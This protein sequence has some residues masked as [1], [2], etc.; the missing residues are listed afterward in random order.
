MPTGTI[1]FL[2]TDVEGSTRLWEYSPTEARAMLARHDALFEAAVDAAGGWVVRPR[3]EGDS[4]FA[5]FRLA[6]E[7][8][9]AALDFQRAMAS[10]PW[11]HAFRVRAALNTGD[12]DLRDGDYYGSAVNRCARLRGL[13]HGGQTLLAETTADLVADTLPDGA[14]LRDLGSHLLKDLSRP[15]RVFQLG[16]ADAP[17]EFPPLASLDALPTNLPG[18]LTVFVGREREVA[19]VA[20]LIR[21][22]RLVTLTG[23]G[24]V[25]KT[26]LALQVAADLVDDHPHGVWFVDLARVSGPEVVPAVVAR[27]IGARGTE[28]GATFDTI[29][30]HLG[31][32][33]TLLV[34]DNCEHLLAA[35]AELV[36]TVLLGCPNVKVLATAREAL[37]SAGEVSWRVPSLSLP[38]ADPRSPH[39]D[40]AAPSTRAEDSEAVQLFLDRARLVAPEASLEPD[41]DVIGQICRRLD[42]IPLA[43]ELAAARVASMAP[44]EIASRLGDRFRLLVGGRRTALERQQTLRAAI[45]WS[46]EPLDQSERSVFRRLSAFVGGFK[47]DA[48]EAVCVGEPVDRSDVA[49]LVGHLVDKSLVLLERSD[50]KTRYRMLETIRQYARE[51][52]L[53]AAESEAVHGAH[54]DFFLA[55]AE[56]A[57]PELHASEQAAWL[58]L[59]RDEQDNLRAALEW[60]EGD[61]GS[62]EKFL[63]GA[64]TLFRFWSLVD[65]REGRRWIEAALAA[66][67]ATPSP[68]RV[69][70]MA[71]A[72]QL[73][74]LDDDPAASGALAQETLDAAR[75]VGDPRS[76]SWALSILG[77]LAAV[78]DP[79][80]APQ[81][82]DEAL[83][84]ARAAGD[85]WAEGLALFGQGNLAFLRDEYRVAR[86]CHDASLALFRKVGD[87]VLMARVIHQGGFVWLLTGDFVAAQGMFEEA[88]ALGAELGDH[89]AV[90]WALASAGFALLGQGDN[91]AALRLCEQG[92]AIARKSQDNVLLSS[93]LLARASLALDAGDHHAAGRFLAESDAAAGGAF[94]GLA[95]RRLRLFGR[96]HYLGD[97][98]TEAQEA[99]EEALR[100]SH[101]V[102][103][104]FDVAE[105]LAE[106]APIIHTEG[107]AET[108]A[109]LVGASAAIHQRLGTVGPPEQ[110]ADYNATTDALRAALGTE[111]FERAYAE[112]T[113]LSVDE[114]VAQ[115]LKP[116]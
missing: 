90:A 110:R 89:R 76:E 103:T 84:V 24:G 47:L 22:A 37:G 95:T 27:A 46:H 58:R 18:Q 68:E 20:Q 96:W 39:G 36:E 63:R 4:R 30:D 86:E 41:L 111:A 105:C 66:V 7:G 6:R 92:L 49:E 113:R 56:Q 8:V 99:F 1:T 71:R 11:P 52:L 43:I 91:E 32:R 57:E 33:S 59:L 107:R 72:M 106:L 5:V 45:D 19:E 94:A 40:N 67:P 79:D 75:I 9:S 93:I 13:A 65:V 88:A 81:L 14:V 51:K 116:K 97:R 101:R 23:A 70:A 28:E 44:A 109:R 77:A 80:R 54:R 53:D 48:A 10:E 115:A 42:G 3:G 74:Y 38:D 100:V 31:D 29:R 50:G 87:G 15:E 21:A 114:A 12:A 60:S 104:P 17:E 55:L 82:L 69:E 102:R 112:G 108:A 25:G 26:R 16:H 34:L 62:A 64:S 35:C 83:S 2:F 98:I 85:D 73:R 78:D 61:P